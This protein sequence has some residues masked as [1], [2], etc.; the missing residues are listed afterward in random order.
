MNW[1]CIVQSYTHI[2]SAQTQADLRE[3]CPLLCP[4]SL[5]P[6]QTPLFNIPM[7][8]RLYCDKDHSLTPHLLGLNVLPIRIEQC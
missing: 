1:R 4:S 5:C 8:G 3:G 6:L 2:H 7:E